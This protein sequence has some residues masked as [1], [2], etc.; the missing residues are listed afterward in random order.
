MGAVVVLP[1]VPVRCTDGYARCGL[2]SRSSS[3]SIRP[4]SNTILVY[5]RRISS[6]STPTSWGGAR[7]TSER[8][9]AIGGRRP[10]LGGDR[11]LVRLARR[12][13]VTDLRDDGGRRL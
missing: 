9:S 1:F 4:R 3:A 7:A 2:P 10:K 13:P 11:V 5:P 8:A 12:E 6:A